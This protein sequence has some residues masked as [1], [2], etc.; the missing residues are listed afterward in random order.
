MRIHS[1]A[2]LFAL[3]LALLPPAMG[4]DQDQAIQEQAERSLHTN[5]VQRAEE[6]M[7]AP[8]KP[9]LDP[10]RIINESYSFLKEREPE[11]TEEEDALYQRVV[12]MIPTEPD[13][14]MRM[15]ENMFS[16]DQPVSAAFDFALANIYFNGG[17]REDAE[18]HYRS[19]IKKYPDFL[20]AWTNLGILCYSSERYPEAI[21]ALAKAITLGDR[22]AGTIGL[23]GYCLIRDGNPVAA[24]MA[25][26]QA[27]AIDP[28][29]SDWVSGLIVVY[30]ESRQ[31][32]RAEPLAKRLI[33]LKPT[34]GTSWLLYAN[35][36]MSE[37]KKMEAAAVLE[38]AAGMNAV[39]EQSYLLLGDVYAEDGFPPEAAA[40]YEKAMRLNHSLGAKR[41]AAYAQELIADGR[42]EDADR[43]L[44][45]AESN[46]APESRPF[47]LEARIDLLTAQQRWPEARREVDELLK[48]DPFNGKAL[49][50]LGQIYKLQGDLPRAT[51]AFEQAYRL[52]NFTYAAA[53]EL[54]NL[55]LQA[56]DFR[57][58]IEYI[59]KALS[60][61]KT[62]A[63]QD[64]LV[65][66]QSLVPENEDNSHTQ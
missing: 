17:R 46:L 58:S 54:S 64:Y 66:L 33:E 42:L 24:E 7:N 10:K 19:A 45:A 16:G 23:M 14:A 63:L 13:F 56:R 6:D 34:E 31:Y 35:L 53:L 11:M 60:I 26:L 55:S 2:A 65:K 59:E 49:L 21:T 28:N 43:V 27:L 52:S 38:T 25:Y 62:S 29:N 18:A 61:Q 32:S 41:L 44:Q 57:K 30:Q 36:L 12:L 39:D 37:G 9:N 22:D 50:R 5:A 48:V 20:R 51:F 47:W 8:Q 1:T 4:Q 3:L 40:A 15:L